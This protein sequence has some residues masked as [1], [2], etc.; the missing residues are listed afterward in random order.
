MSYIQ[1]SFSDSDPCG[2]WVDAEIATEERYQS[3]KRGNH[4]ASIVEPAR[5]M[6]LQAMTARENCRKQAGMPVQ[7]VVQPGRTKEETVSNLQAE[8]ARRQAA[9]DTQAAAK[10]T[11][12]AVEIQ[13]MPATA[14]TTKPQ[15]TSQPQSTNFTDI[16][17][18][19]SS[20]LNPLATAGASA[21]QA[22]QQAKLAQ[23]QLRQQPGAGA[24][25]FMFPGFSPAPKDNTIL[26]VS[27]AGGAAM[28]LLIIAMVAMK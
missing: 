13:K 21:Y 27:I 10:L 12:T 23:L 19:I 14:V 3:L 25:S 24:G 7:L 6:A 5:I 4:P 1:F 20:L 17:A 26:I 16:A 15:A 8:A 2:Q 9:G 11:A 22:Q 18:G 28:L